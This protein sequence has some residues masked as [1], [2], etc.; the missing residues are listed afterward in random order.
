MLFVFKILYF[1][2]HQ[3]WINILM[4]DCDLSDI[5]KLIKKK[6]SFYIVG[7]LL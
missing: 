4:D 3:I 6:H 7:Y 1:E 2:Y 5:P